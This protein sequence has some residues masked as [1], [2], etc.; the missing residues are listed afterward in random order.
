MPTWEELRTATIEKWEHVQTL[1]PEQDTEA[2]I[3]AITN[4][5]SFCEYAEELMNE[6]AADRRCDYCLH[7]DRYGSCRGMMVKVLRQLN[8]NRWERLEDEVTGILSYLAS[9]QE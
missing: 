7:A 1:L 6:G 8:A 4:A 5:C 9:I 2:V 3:E